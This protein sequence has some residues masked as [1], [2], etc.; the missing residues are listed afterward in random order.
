[1]LEELFENVNR[2]LIFNRANALSETSTFR[3]NL[4]IYI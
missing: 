3:W 1:M 4:C 2:S